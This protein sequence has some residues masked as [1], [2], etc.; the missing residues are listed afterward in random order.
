MAIAARNF[1]V[2]TKDGNPAKRRRFKKG[3]TV[4]PEWVAVISG[5]SLLETEDTPDPEGGSPAVPGSGSDGGNPPADPFADDPYP[6]T[7]GSQD[8]TDNVD[9]VL[10]WVDRGETDSDKEHRAMH[11]LAVETEDGTV[12]GR[13]TLVTP[14]RELLGITEE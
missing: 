10:G 2:N 9:D 1:T 12:K 8:E 5:K 6:G 13:T 4:P 7:D 11:A 14:L 3:E